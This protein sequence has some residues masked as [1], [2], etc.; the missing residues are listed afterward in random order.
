MTVPGERRAATGQVLICGRP[1]VLEETVV[2]PT[3]KARRKQRSV[4]A[5]VV[6]AGRSRIDAV[7][8][9]PE[10][11][12]ARRELGQQ[13]GNGV[14][15]LTQAGRKAGDVVAVPPDLV[16]ID[17]VGKQQAVT[18]LP[19]VAAAGGKPRRVV[20][21]V[22]VDLDAALGEDLAD[23][24]DADHRHAGVVQQVEIGRTGRRQREVA[25]SRGALEAAR[26][27]GERPGDDAPDRVREAKDAARDRAPL[28]EELDRHDVFV[29]GHLK[30]G[31]GR[32]VDDRTSAAQVLLA[33]LVE[34]RGA[35]RRTVTQHAAPDGRAERFDHLRRKTVRIGR[36][37]HPQG[38]PHHLPVAGRRVLA[39]ATLEQAPIRSPGARLAQRQTHDPAQAQRGE[40]GQ[41]DVAC[42]EHVTKGVRAA[43]AVG[44]GVGRFS[45]PDAV[46]HAHQDSGHSSPFWGL[47]EPLGA[48][49]LAPLWS[50]R[51]WERPLRRGRSC[52][53]AHAGG[54]CRR[55]RAGGRR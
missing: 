8:G 48:P 5:R 39:G 3:G 2:A 55:P 29:A 33:E 35:R 47:M 52:G 9:T 12:V 46:E 20:R 15:Y 11:D 45:R 4:L 13:P 49:P 16:E 25:P 44:F 6:G 36:E 41:L 31:V 24:A 10:G 40:V 43:I 26:A 14:V 19:Q 53:A 27:T 18:H 7:I 42:L 23:L 32:R 21:G 38:Q 50:P 34:D 28:V 51:T 30:D 22:I 1:D 54:C 17:E 37:R